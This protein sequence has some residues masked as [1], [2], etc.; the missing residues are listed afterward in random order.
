MTELK[1]HTMSDD[2]SDFLYKARFPKRREGSEKT[3]AQF[4]WLKENGVGQFRTYYHH[5]EE[6]G[7]HRRVYGFTDENTACEFKLRFGQDV[8]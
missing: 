7:Q 8:E 6:R 4:D 1:W 3:L 5:D 2:W